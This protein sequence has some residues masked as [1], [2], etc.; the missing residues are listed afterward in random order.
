M[1]AGVNRDTDRGGELAGDASF[2]CIVR[3]LSHTF[4]D[5]EISYLQL[6]QGETTSSSYTAVVLNRWATD[7]WSQLVNR[8]RCDCCSLR[9]TSITTSELSAGLG[10]VC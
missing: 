7:D 3:I 2:L 5:P 9:E 8:S 6:G 10:I 1:A 4:C